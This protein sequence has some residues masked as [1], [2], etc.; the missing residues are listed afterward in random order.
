MSWRAAILFAAG[1]VLAACGGG[2]DNRIACPD[3]EVLRDLSE[4]TRF[5]PG[6]GRDPTD[7]LLEAWVE[8]VNGTCLLDDEDLIVDLTVRILTRR[9]PANRAEGAEI[10]YFVAVTDGQRNVLSRQTFTTNAAYVSRKS[11]SFEDVLTLSIPLV[12]GMATDS[13]LIYVGLELSENELRHNR[14]K[15]SR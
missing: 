14:S 15:S 10:P 13:F 1:F 7:V 5:N 11:I 12:P 8:R 6:P 9:G 2:N 3:V 4:V